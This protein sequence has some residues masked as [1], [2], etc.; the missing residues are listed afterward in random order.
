MLAARLA[1]SVAIVPR[2]C[3]R[4]AGGAVAEDHFPARSRV[5]RCGARRLSKDRRRAV[6]AG[7][8]QRGRE[9][10]ERRREPLDSRVATTA[11]GA[12]PDRRGDDAAVAFRRS[13]RR[14]AWSEASV[15]SWRPPT[16][17]A[18]CS[19]DRPRPPWSRR[20]RP[21]SLIARWPLASERQARRHPAMAVRSTCCV[22][23][24]GVARIVR[25][26]AGRT[27][28]IA[29]SSGSA[30]RVRHSWTCDTWYASARSVHATRRTASDTA[31]FPWP[32]ASTKE[33][34]REP[35]LLEG[36]V[37]LD[38]RRRPR[39]RPRHRLGDGRGRREGR[40]QRPRRVARRPGSATTQ[41]AQRGRDARSRHRRRGDRRR[42]L[43]G[44]L[45]RAHN[46]WSR[47]R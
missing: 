35:S 30:R 23:G 10:G 27:R 17:Q 1:S 3:R 40:R 4:A 5:E 44:R 31:G 21:S 46:A 11:E 9:L 14:A 36:K 39:R 2:R 34:D 8:A 25:W 29:R 16:A 15:S 18:R 38:H 32:H 42:R 45:G 37:A 24:A 22:R 13:R 6:G 12:M 20:L 26:P 41:P 43:G 28:A 7:P 19:S 33:T 47:R